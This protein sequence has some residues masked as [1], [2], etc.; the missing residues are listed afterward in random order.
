MSGMLMSSRIKF[1]GSCRAAS[2]ASLPLGTGR[3]LYPRSLSMPAKTCKLVGV[4]STTRML[5]G[6]PAPLLGFSRFNGVPSDL[7]NPGASG[8]G[9]LRPGGADPEQCG[10]SGLQ[11][12]GSL[13]EAGPDPP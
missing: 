10:D 4:S 1:G 9:S 8:I 13:R 6:S 2:S 11:P 5:A 3:T 12:P 7:A